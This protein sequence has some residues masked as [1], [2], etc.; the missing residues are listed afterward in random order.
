MKVY[1]ELDSCWNKEHIF[2]SANAWIRE[3]WHD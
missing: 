1:G 2:T 3:N